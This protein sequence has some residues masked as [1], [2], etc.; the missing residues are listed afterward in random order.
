MPYTIPQLLLLS[1]AHASPSPF[2]NLCV[3]GEQPSF[4]TMIHDHIIKGSNIID[5]VYKLATQ[6]QTAHS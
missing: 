1:Y 4:K 3:M 5:K 6:Y 2:T